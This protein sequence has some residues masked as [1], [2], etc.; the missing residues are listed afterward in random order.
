M[1][2]SRAVCSSVLAAPAASRAITCCW[3]DRRTL[4]RDLLRLRLRLRLCRLPA[5]TACAIGWSLS[6]TLGTDLRRVS[7]RGMDHRLDSPVGTD[8]FQND[9]SV[10]SRGCT[11]TGGGCGTPLRFA[12]RAARRNSVARLVRTTTGAARLRG[13]ARALNTGGWVFGS[14][15][16]LRGSY[17]F[18]R[19]RLRPACGLRRPS[20]RRA[21]VVVGVSLLCRADTDVAHLLRCGC[22]GGCGTDAA[23]SH[24]PVPTDTR[25][26][27][28]D[29]G[30]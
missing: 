29:T 20:W 3:W 10:L 15:G 8:T 25:C 17:S 1:R 19:R 23:V 5:A 27:D 11:G 28:V 16:A 24:R 13:G 7:S 21:V 6:L 26:P 30:T 12:C 9:A 18:A 14:V 22:D 4:A 2:R